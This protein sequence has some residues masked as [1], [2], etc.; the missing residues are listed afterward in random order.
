MSRLVGMGSDKALT[1]NDETVEK[2]KR[3]LKKSE[4]ENANLSA[5]K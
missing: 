2:S 1:E 3:K 5:K 4:K